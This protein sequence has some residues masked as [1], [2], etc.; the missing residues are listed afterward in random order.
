MDLILAHRTCAPIY[1]NTWRTTSR[2]GVVSC[3]AAIKTC[4]AHFGSEE[5]TILAHPLVD[6]L[7]FAFFSV[8]DIQQVNISN[9]NLLCLASSLKYF[10][11]RLLTR[12]EQILCHLEYDVKHISRAALYQFIGLD[13]PPWP[14]FR[15]HLGFGIQLQL[16]LTT[17]LP[18]LFTSS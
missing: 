11:L 16:V 3:G 7:V 17:T 1:R 15:I 2:L 4:A 14:R 9:K 6:P 5:I 8:V 18:R 12:S 13:M 10:H